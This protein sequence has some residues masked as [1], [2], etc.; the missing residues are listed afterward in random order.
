MTQRYFD[1]DGELPDGPHGTGTERPTPNPPRTPTP[2]P[3]QTPTQTPPPPESTGCGSGTYNN[4][5]NSPKA[6][7]GVTIPDGKSWDPKRGRHTWTTGPGSICPDGSEVTYDPVAKTWGCQGDAGFT[8]T[9]NPDDDCPRRTGTP[10]PPSTPPPPPPGGVANQPTHPGTY[11]YEP[12]T[13]PL[14]DIQP[15]A[16]PNVRPLEYEPFAG[17]EPFVAPNVR[18]IEYE[19]FVAPTAESLREDPGYQFRRTEGLNAVL[20]SAASRGLSRGGSALKALDRYGQGHASE[21]YDRAHGRA[22]TEHGIGRTA[23]L[24]Q[25]GSDVG[26]FNRGATTHGIGRTAALD[27]YGA[28]RQEGLDQHGADVGAHGRQLNQ[29]LVN[30]GNQ[31]DQ[32]NRSLAGWTSNNRAGLAG[33]QTNTGAFDQYWARLL[34]QYGID[35]STVPPPYVPPPPAPPIFT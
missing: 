34:Q 7:A 30:T 22:V 21:E 31:A 8:P 6:P 18:P 35:K 27:Q 1:P 9:F 14:P 3:T 24:D 17:Y 29:Y 16:G 26:A 15:F 28:G 20:H 33:Y 10:P 11:S 5:W 23:A 12:F 25:Y 19:P 32:W 2:T 13:T 4:Q